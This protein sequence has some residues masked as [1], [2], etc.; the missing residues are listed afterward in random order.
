MQSEVTWMNTLKSCFCLLKFTPRLGLNELKS[1]R[2]LML[3]EFI[4]H[5]EKLKDINHILS[6]LLHSNWSLSCLE[7]F[8]MHL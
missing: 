1:K 6:Q 5:T 3:E 7:T 4:F 8:R 2:N